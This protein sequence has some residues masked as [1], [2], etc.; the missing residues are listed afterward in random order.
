VNS[1]RVNR[2]LTLGANLGVLVGII[3]LLVEL[4]QNR[5]MMKA[6]IRHQIASEEA[7]F[8][9]ETAHNRDVLEIVTRASRGEELEDFD[10]MQY[11]WRLAG[12]FKLQENI[13]YQARNGLFDESEYRGIKTQWKQFA[14]T[15]PNLVSIWCVWRMNFSK[16]FRDDFDSVI[17]NLDCG[18]I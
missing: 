3:L 16:D 12:W 10:M 4:D 2:W 6:Q 15:S 13:H 14:S 7:N 1:D 9:F 8:A 5:E 18:A 17:E 11:G